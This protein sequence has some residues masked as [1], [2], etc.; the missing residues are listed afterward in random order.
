MQRIG[1]A[2][3]VWGELTEDE[4]LRSEGR[5]ECLAGLLEERYAISCE[6]ADAQV[7]R[8]LESVQQSWLRRPSTVQDT[9]QQ[10]AP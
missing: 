1:A 7:R 10:R 6:A 8:F 9:A 2:K 5:S 4:L 3:L